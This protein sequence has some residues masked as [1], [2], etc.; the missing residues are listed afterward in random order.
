[1][2]SKLTFLCGFRLLTSAFSCQTLLYTNV[3]VC[4]DV[5]VNTVA[6]VLTLIKRKIILHS[7]EHDLNVVL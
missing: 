6:A 3:F 7:A 1:M 4:L 5:A 2:T